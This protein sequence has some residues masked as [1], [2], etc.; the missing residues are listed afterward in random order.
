MTGLD[1]ALNQTLD[2]TRLQVSALDASKVYL[3]ATDMDG[4]L[5]RDDRFSPELLADLEAL[6][7]AGLPQKGLVS[8]S[9]L[10]IT[11]QKKEGQ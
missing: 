5:T 3:I 2:T 7:A 6:Q 4:T 8:Q 11:I 1:R 9:R 10:L